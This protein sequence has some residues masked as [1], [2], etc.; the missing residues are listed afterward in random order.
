MPKDVTTCRTQP[1]GVWE[2]TSRSLTWKIAH[3][4]PSATPLSFVA[5][6]TT[7]TSADSGRSGQPL[8][9]QFSS[10]TYNLAGV[11]LRMSP[12]SAIGRVLQRFV[13]GKYIVHCS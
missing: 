5:D 3:L 13:S 2:S 1:Q 4:P 11:Q 10:E 12:P 9:V 7:G 6:F 8:H